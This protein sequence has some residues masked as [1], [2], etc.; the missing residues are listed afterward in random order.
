MADLILRKLKSSLN[1]F[2]YVQCGV[3]ILSMSKHIMNK[4]LTCADDMNIRSI[5]QDIGSIHLNYGDVNKLV[6]RYRENAI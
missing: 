5:F 1:H 3:G 2:N 4:V 6:D